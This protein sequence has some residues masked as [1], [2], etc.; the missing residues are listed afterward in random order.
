MDPEDVYL[1]ELVASLSQITEGVTCGVDTSQASHTP[2]YTDQMIEALMAS[3]RRTV[4]DYSGGINRSAPETPRSPEMPR[5]PYEFP[6]AIGTTEYGIGRIVRKYFSSRDQLVTLGLNAGPTDVT[7]PKTGELQPYTGWQLAREFGALINN[8]NVGSPQTVI[9]AAADPRNGT[10]WSDVT[11]VHCTRWQDN[12]IAQIS[13]DHLG[14]PNP[15]TS[16]AWQIFSERGGHASIANL[17][18]MQMRHGMPPLQLALNHGILPSLSPDV[19][20]NMTPDPFSI[21]RGTFCLQRLLGNVLT[22]PL[23]DP[24]RLPTPQVVTARQV[25]EMATIAGAA[26]NGVLQ[27]VGTLSPG[28]EADIV[29]LDAH[30]INIAPMN[31]VPGTVVTMMDTSHVRHVVIA[32]KVMVWHRKLVGWNVRKLVRDVINARD[33]VLARINGRSKT[34]PLP[35]G[36]NSESSPYRPNFLGSCCFNGQNTTA[37]LYQLRP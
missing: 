7:D 21:M 33:Q 22:I 13:Y 37:P 8:H 16:Q 29:V 6:G 25:I 11:L 1:A 9:D 4:Y 23:E 14:Y 35:P 12:P 31:N 18:E 3:G 30:N 34:G 26:G 5:Q 36:M 2:E 19:D 24:G 10:D 20:T 27:K 28:K 17:I 15:A 32:G